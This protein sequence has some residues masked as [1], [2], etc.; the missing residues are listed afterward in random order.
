[1]E[2]MISPDKLG[3]SLLMANWF[4]KFTVWLILIPIIFPLEFLLYRAMMK[5]RNQLAENNT[6]GHSLLSPAIDSFRATFMFGA[7]LL[8]FVALTTEVLEGPRL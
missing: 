6:N 8:G 4:V 3:K 7:L 5:A 2:E 1:M